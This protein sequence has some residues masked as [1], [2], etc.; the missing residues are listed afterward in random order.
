MKYIKWFIIIAILLITIIG[1]AQ[2]TYY[3]NQITITWD[4][5]TTYE[6][7]DLL[8]VDLDIYYDVYIREK[9]ELQIYLGET[10]GITYLITFPNPNK[11]YDIGVLAKYQLDNT[12]FYSIVNWSIDD[13]LNM[14]AWDVGFFVPANSPINLRIE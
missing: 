2:T 9:G 8:P 4:A 11:Y 6:N 14:E 3:A 1:Y 7:G 13:T 5:P 10:I 12:W